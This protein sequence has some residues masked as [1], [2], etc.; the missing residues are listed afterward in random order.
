LS[1]VDGVDPRLA[2]HWVSVKAGR[3]TAAGAPSFKKLQTLRD[4]GADHVVT[5]LRADEPACA[6][7]MAGCAGLELGWTHLPM[8]GAKLDAPTD[9]K[10]FLRLYE[11]LP[12]LDQG[13]SVVVH[14]A[15]GMHR[16]GMSCYALLRL[17]GWSAEDACHGVKGMREV[18]YEEL[19]K[20]RR[21]K[22]RCQDTAEAFVLP[23]LTSAHAN[24]REAIESERERTA[25][26]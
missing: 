19:I 21:H 12:L 1:T 18:S 8:S 3:L 24:E 4:M 20:D 6:S 9:A 23:M 13:K 25:L 11:V 17:A 5:L 16:T 10:S 7:V 15:A 2:S 26:G 22:R 14:C